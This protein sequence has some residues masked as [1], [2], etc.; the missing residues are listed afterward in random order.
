MDKSSARALMCQ[1]TIELGIKGLLYHQ[2]HHQPL[3]IPEIVH[4]ITLKSRKKSENHSKKITWVSHVCQRVHLQPP[5]FQK[6]KKG[7]GK[8]RPGQGVWIFHPK[9]RLLQVL[10]PRGFV[11]DMILKGILQW[12]NGILKG[13]NGIL[14][15]F[16]GIGYNDLMVF[17]SDLM[18][19]YN[20]LMVFL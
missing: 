6:G 11:R 13:F 2:Y 12:F 8:P 10:T 14:Q 3:S 5:P 7:R 17:Y 16:N 9:V 1:Q 4:S 19:F 20:D 18:V 15:W